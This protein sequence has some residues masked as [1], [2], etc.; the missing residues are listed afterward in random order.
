MQRITSNSR[1]ILAA[2]ST[3][4]GQA[5]YLTST[6]G[7]LN[8]NATFNASSIALQDG[9]NSSIKATVFDLANSNPLSTQI[10]DANG[11]AITSFGG[12]TQYTDGAVAPAHAVGTMPVFN[13]LGNISQVTDSIGLPVSIVSVPVVVPIAA[14]NGAAITVTGS[15]VDVNITN[16]SLTVD[17][18]VDGH[19]SDGDPITTGNPVWVA[20]K[21]NATPPTYTDGDQTSL[22]SDIAGNLLV[23]GAVLDTIENDLANI[24]TD[25]GNMSSALSVM[26]D[27]VIPIDTAVGATNATSLVGVIRKDTPANLSGTDGDAETLQVSNGR[28]WAST[29][30]DTA[31]PAGSNLVGKVGIDQTTPGTTNNVSLSVS[32]GSNTSVLVKDDP[33]FGDGVTSGVGSVHSRLYNG[34][35]YDRWRSVVNGTNSTGTGIG[36]IG[37]LAQVDDTSPTSITENQFGNVR[38]STDRSLLVTPRSTTPTQTSVAGNASSVSLLAANSSRKGATITNDSSALLYIKLGTTASTTSYTAVLA[39]AAA[40][41]FAYYEVPFG[42]VGAIDGIWASATGNA[43]IT[44]LA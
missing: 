32:T 21:Y 41:P 16:G 37:I 2:Q 23:G 11:D 33:S 39:G 34:S 12:G 5:E 31:L 10:V 28:L 20:S 15:A 4:T 22:Q 1:E 19:T 29:K 17:A 26:Q 6:N 7:I 27:V 14:S 13:N 9:S 24:K 44:E 43:R 42:Y 8:V 38:M 35:S 36:A 25:T 18:I 3:I 30:I 40:A